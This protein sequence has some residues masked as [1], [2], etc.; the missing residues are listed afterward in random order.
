[1]KAA[2]PLG[3]L[4]QPSDVADAVTWLLSDHSRFITG[5]SIPVDGGRS[6]GGHGL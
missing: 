2:I 4:P 5:A 3:A 1:M 6:M